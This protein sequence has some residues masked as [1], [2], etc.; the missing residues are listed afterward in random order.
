MS[1][2]PWARVD[3]SGACFRSV[4][5]LRASHDTCQDEP[6]S[7]KGSSAVPGTAQASEAAGGL[8]QRTPGSTSSRW[9]QG[10]NAVP[11]APRCSQEAE[12]QRLSSLVH[13]AGEEG[14]D[15]E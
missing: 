13:S 3:S 2:R 7:S 4:G 6:S 8:N 11:P 12:S 5:W 15:T 10:G 9:C 1:R 14:Q